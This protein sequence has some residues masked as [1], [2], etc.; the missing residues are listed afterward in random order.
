[1]DDLVRAYTPRNE[2]ELAMLKGLLAQEGISFYVQN[3]NF[4][5]LKAGPQIP[6][7]N[8]RTIMI[9]KE[10]YLEAK[11]IINGFM[12]SAYEEDR[13][14]TYQYT[15]KEKLRMLLEIVLFGWVVPGKRKWPK[16]RKLQKAIRTT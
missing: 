9:P 14:D 8:A 7:F 10:Q 15:F 1:M 11:E 5:A 12:S 13:K 6:L 3:E 4:G 16:E 2:V